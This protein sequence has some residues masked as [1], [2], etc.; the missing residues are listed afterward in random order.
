MQLVVKLYYAQVRVRSA[1]SWFT[2][3]LLHITDSETLMSAVPS[4]SEMFL[5]YCHALSG[6]LDL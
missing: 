3:P 1:V 6:S 2:F 5:F 4:L